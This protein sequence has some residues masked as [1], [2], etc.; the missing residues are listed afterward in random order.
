MVAAGVEFVSAPQRSEDGSA[1]VV[2]GRT[3]DGV[4]LE[5]VELFKG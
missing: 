4:F 1:K 3:P 5:L 2:F